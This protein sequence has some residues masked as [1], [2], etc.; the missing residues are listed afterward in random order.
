MKNLKGHNM[1]RSFFIILFLGTFLILSFIIQ[2]IMLLVGL[3]SK[4][5]RDRA[6][7]SIV[8]WVFRV[9][10]WMSGCEVTYLGLENIPQD[11]AVL[12]VMNHRGFFDILFT[13]VKTPRPTG[14]VAKVELKNFLT[15]SWWMMLLHCQFMDRKDI[16]KGLACINECAEEIKRGYSITIYP[17]GTRNKTN[18]P[19]QEFHKGSLKIAEKAGCKI[20][21]VSVC[22]T[23]NVFENHLPLIYKQHVVV[24]YLPAIDVASMSRDEKKELAELTQGLIR[25]AYVK[26]MEK[27]Y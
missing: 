18:E 13:Y 22:N 3:F 17:E 25:D 4:P 14:Y 15:L 5:A 11:E 23:E 16:K 10:N 1:I 2:P 7:L 6:S 26:N 27:Y 21:P 8:Q 20:I 19:I 9:I 24:E 12:F